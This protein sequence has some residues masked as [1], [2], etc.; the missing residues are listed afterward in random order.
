M[1]LIKQRFWIVRGRSTVSNILSKCVTCRKR[2]AT[3]CT[4]KMADLPE[5]RVTP[6]NPPFTAVGVDYFGTFNVAR[7]RGT[8][9]RYGCV[10]TCLTVRAV[11]IEIAH[12]LDTSSFINALQRFISRRGQPTIIRSD[13]GTNLVGGSKELRQ[14]IQEWNQNKIEDHLRQQEIA[15][16]FNP[17]YASHDGRCVGATNKDNPKSYHVCSETT[18]IDR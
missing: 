13:N 15:W 18:D 7:G 17:P 3:P 2:D 4:Q 12:S 9:K 10:F 1:S 11:H 16:V 6:N 5:D 8:V 14:A